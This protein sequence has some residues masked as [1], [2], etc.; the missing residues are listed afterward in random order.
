MTWWS[1]KGSGEWVQYSFGQPRRVSGVRVYWFDDRAG[2]G[3]CAVPS[4][5][6]VLVRNGDGPWQSVPG[7]TDGGVE[8]DRFNSMAFEPVVAEEIRLQVQLRDGCSGGILEWE[9]V[10][11]PCAAAQP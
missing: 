5:W 3:G 7:A 2:N 11:E 8:P 1:H 10:S 4:A 9:V 6:K